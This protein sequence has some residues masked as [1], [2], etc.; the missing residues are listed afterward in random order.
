MPLRPVPRPLGLAMTIA[1]PTSIRAKL[2]ALVAIAVLVATLIAAA[3]SAIRETDRRLEARTAELDGIAAV[4]ATA[5]APATAKSDRYAALNAIRAMARIPRLAHVAVIEPSGRRLAELGDAVVVMQ[6]DDGHLADRHL[7]RV[8]PIVLSGEQIGTI[9]LIADRS[10][11]DEAFRESM[12]SALAAGLVAALVGI[13]LATRLQ[14]LVTRPIADLVAAMDDVRATSSFDRV[15]P[16]TTRDE[17]GKLVAAFND[18]LRHI[19]ER[20]DLLARHR[21]RLEADV[22][23]RTADLLEARNVA[24]RAN[25]AK[26]DFLATMSHEIRTPMSGMLVMAELLATSRLPPKLQR[27]SDVILRSGRGLLSII[28]DILDFS[29]IEAGKLDIEAIP[30]EPA[31]IADDIARL[32]AERAQGKGLELAVDVAPDVPAEIIGD[33]VRLGQIL[34]NLVNN[35]LKFTESGSVTIRLSA[36]PGTALGRRLVIEVADTGIGIPEDKQAAI[37]DAFS[38]ADQST[39]RRF[40]GTGIGLAICRRLTEAMGGA[41]TLTSVVGVGTTFRV[42]IPIVEADVA[43]A[44]SSVAPSG[45]NATTATVA[46]REVTGRVLLALDPGPT[47]DI[48]ARRIAAAGWRVMVDPPQT[49]DGLAPDATHAF[50]PDLDIGAIVTRPAELSACVERFHAAPGCQIGLLSAFGDGEAQALVERG[51]AGHVVA[52]PLTAGD[53]GEL[54]EWLAGRTVEA[55]PSLSTSVAEVALVR[56]RFVGRHVLAADDSQVNREILVEALRPLGVM[57]TT[58]ENGREA[59]EAVRAGHFDLVLMDGSMPEMDGFEAARAIRAL[60]AE[61]GRRPTPIVALTAHVVGSQANAWRDA[62]MNDYVTKPFTLR[63]LE[64]ALDRWMSPS[65]AEAIAS[66]DAPQSGADTSKPT[67]ATLDIGSP[68]TAEPILDWEVVADIRALGGD[69]LLQRVAG[70]FAVHAPAALETLGQSLATPDVTPKAVATAAHA[71]RS[72]CRNMGAMKLAALAAS[73]E[74]AGRDYGDV[75]E[76]AT[77]MPALAEAMSA[78]LDALAGL[79]CHPVETRDMRAAAE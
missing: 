2:A 8:A 48:L 47:R 14:S 50:E 35:A 78:T 69:N 22:A 44:A 68:P 57:L 6:G 75:P 65:D 19:R 71:L 1:A 5:V 30:V 41:I 37:F 10:D 33:P 74:M 26:S 49:M 51:V 60:E 36:T 56:G 42:E 70:L 39:T 64:S 31:A 4:L 13:L 55:R 43:A 16:H 7:V 58:V 61:T 45:A 67:V 29:K 15:V 38:Q 12:M 62:G 21:D 59:L 73:I 23:A 66:A 20:D 25:A 34:S 24:E 32:F 46:A 54:L 79:D 53:V 72:V 77:V 3:A 11:L 27:Y 63:M 17:T 18:M 40:G 28:N 9:R 52:T 76:V